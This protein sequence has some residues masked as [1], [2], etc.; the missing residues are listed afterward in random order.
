MKKMIKI[1][2][3]TVQPDEGHNGVYNNL[4]KRKGLKKYGK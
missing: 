4:F 2:P 3:S 1:Q